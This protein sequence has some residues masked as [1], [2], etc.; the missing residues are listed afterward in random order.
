VLGSNP[1]ISTVPSPLQVPQQNT[2]ELYTSNPRVKVAGGNSQTGHHAIYDVPTLPL[3]ADSIPSSPQSDI[4]DRDTPVNGSLMTEMALRIP[5]KC[6]PAQD[7]LSSSLHRRQRFIYFLSDGNRTI[8]DIARCTGKS[9]PEVVEIL[10]ELLQKQ[11]IT[12]Q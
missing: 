8:N 7:M 6:E 4:Q 12:W 3:I 11:L 1:A 5:R 2:G 9:G 10:S